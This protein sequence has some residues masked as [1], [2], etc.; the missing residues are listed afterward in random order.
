MVT[1][2]NEYYLKLYCIECKYGA[3]V[4]TYINK[5]RLGLSCSDLKKTIKDVYNGICILRNYDVRDIG[6]TEETYNTFTLEEMENL[7]ETLNT[8]LL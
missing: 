6:L 8:K 4:H 1:T 2:S 7:I 3:K 5:L